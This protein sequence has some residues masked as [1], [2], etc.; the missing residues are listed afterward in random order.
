MCARYVDVNFVIVEKKDSPSLN[1]IQDT[2]YGYFSLMVPSLH[3]KLKWGISL[4]E[5][6]HDFF[7][8]L[9]RGLRHLNPYILAVPNPKPPSGRHYF[10]H[11]YFG[12]IQLSNSL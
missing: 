2:A 6:R 5:E 12:K 11:L 3:I 10:H 1:H 7:F 9:K 4:K 8:F